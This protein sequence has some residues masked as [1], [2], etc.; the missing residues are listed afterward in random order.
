MGSPRP[1]RPQRST[2]ST[3][4]TGAVRRVATLPAPTAYGA[5]V[6]FRGALYLI[7]GKSAAGVPLTSV[8]RIDPASGR[9][10]RVATLPR[11]LAEPAAV[12]R[13][14]D[15]IVVGGENSNAV[16]SLS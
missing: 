8:L 15:V 5:L 11:P 12:A 2:P 1:A 16:Y 13:A 10:A 14:G 4:R 9:V 6:A 7:G 3:P